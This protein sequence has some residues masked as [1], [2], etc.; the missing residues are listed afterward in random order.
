VTADRATESTIVAPPA[1]IRPGSIGILGGTFDPIHYGHLGIAEEAREALGLERVLVMPAGEPPHKPDRPIA[2][3][4]DRVAMVE[5]AIAD[6]QALTLG[7]LEVDRPGPSFAVDT[8]EALAAAER[9]AGRTPDLTFILSAEAL[10]GLALWREPARLLELCRLA[11][12]PRAGSASF[13]GAGVAALVEPFAPGGADRVILLDGPRIA[14]SG[15]VIRA[16]VAAGRSI[17][18]LV[19]GAVAAYIGARGLYRTAPYTDPSWRSRP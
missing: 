8:L 13:D 15:S 3:V 2:A 4:E 19:S 18:Y 10:A 12:V 16:R 1:P 11:V 6:N 9:A 7:R 5:L 17:R 14:I